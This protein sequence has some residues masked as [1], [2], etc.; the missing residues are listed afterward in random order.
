M[1]RIVVSLVLAAFLIARP[2]AAQSF[3]EGEFDPAIPT[4]SEEIGHAPG[5]RITAPDNVVRYIEALHEAAPERTRLVEY[6]RSW[7]GRPLY[8]L[9]ISSPENM[10]RLETNKANMARLASGEAGVDVAGLVGS[11]VPV[12]WLTYG[13]HGNEI[14]SSDAALALAYHLL[15]SRNDELVGTILANSI[16]VID[17]SQNPDGRARFVQK[18]REQLG[19]EPMGD[20]NTA[21]HDEPWPGGRFNHYLFDLNRDWFTLSQPETVG[22]VAAVRDWHPVVLVDAHEMS[23]DDTYF[24][25]PSADPFNPN[26][27]PDQR[28]KQVLLGRNHARWF[29][30]LGIPYFTR[31]V[32]DA[33]YPGYGDTW[34]TLNGAIASTFEQGSARGLVWERRDGTLLT[35]REGV[36]NHFLATLSTAETVAKNADTFLR[37]YASYRR[38]ARAATPGGR[39]VIDL[40]EKRWNA[41]SLARRLAFQ[42]IAV[43]RV[44]G[45]ASACGRSYPMGYLSVDRAQPNGRLIRS[46]LDKDTPLPADFVREQE[47]RR[48][49]D[50]PH[51]LYDVTAWSVGYM[52]GLDVQLCS[53][54]GGGS[55]VTASDPIAPMSEGSGDYAVAVP[56]TD[57]GQAKLVVAA[58]D[59][60]LSGRTTSEAFRTAGREFGRGTV[61][62]SR[63]DNTPEQ[64]ASLRTLASSIGAQT[65]DLAESW[66]DEGPNLGSDRFVRLTEPKVAMIWG[67]GVSPLSAGALRYVIERRLGIPVA[68]IRSDR[69]SRAD[70]DRYDVLLVPQGDVAG[71]IGKSGMEGIE[72]F[73]ERGGVLV[74]IGNA[75]AGFSGSDDALL[76]TRRET[77]LQDASKE[78]RKGGSSS[79]DGPAE[80]TEITSEAEYRASVQDL[81]ASPDE[82]PGALL[83]TV[84]DTDHFLSS[85]YDRGPVVL[86]SGSLI[87]QPLGEADGTN[88]IRFADAG[89]LVASGYVW[90]EN[91]RQLAYKPYLM[92]QSR[93]RGMVIGFTQDPATRAYLDGLDLLI[94]NAI[95]L[96][97]SRV[98]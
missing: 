2:A 39:Y 65:V 27:T 46:L 92:A 29:D 97:P 18:Y 71:E 10:A 53:G 95:L 82:L 72:G 70:L 40:A 24:F 8:Y 36:R 76:A 12:T 41:E 48:D 37:D 1:L 94:A 63:A 78:E 7:E 81:K 62:F 58:L 43:R 90:D 69:I 45:P 44:E 50:L 91:R 16:V 19:L 55:L 68:P 23:G 14:S 93:G 47:E 61:I 30:M 34:P 49:R 35:Y 60:G 56:W 3:L 77:G 85:G 84:S 87:F 83:R 67:D 31:E 66:V 38:A 32:Y 15:A 9:V 59:A 52:S 28:Q 88:V 73:V 25:P 57:S 42:G 22:K 80:G 4:L 86:A 89:D 13:V 11:T 51:E 6:A 75:T 33:F 79:E 17:P 20:R 96:A 5:E 26:I 98:R 64:L 54:A 21:G 74:T